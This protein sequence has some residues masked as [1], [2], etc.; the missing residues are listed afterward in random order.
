MRCWR[1]KL[2]GLASAIRIRAERRLGELIK[3]QKETVG[4]ADGGDATKARFQTSTELKPTLA[5]AGIS[6]K[7]SALRSWQ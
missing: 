2:R 4:L 7:L 5:E 1:V 6:K 3:R